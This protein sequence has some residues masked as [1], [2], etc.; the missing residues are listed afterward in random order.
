MGTILLVVVAYLV[1]SLQFAVL[2]SRLFGLADPRTYGSGNPGATNVLRSGNKKA[3]LLTLLGDTAKGWVVV[4]LAV[5]YGPL[6]NVDETGIALAAVAVFCG[7]IL[8]VFSRFRGGKGVATAL[9]VLLGINPLL[10]GAVLLTWLLVAAV[11]RYSSLSALLS[12]VLAPVYQIWLDGWNTLSAAI[13]CIA[14]LLIIRHAGNIANLARGK[15]NRI[16]DVLK[17]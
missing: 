1:G 14:V 9:G 5:R 8:P 11:S 16:G 12:A 13:L 17:K 7:H 2:T 4:W 3:A 15:E 6:W 10:G